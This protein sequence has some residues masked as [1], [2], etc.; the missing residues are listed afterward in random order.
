MAT[1]LVKHLRL[2]LLPGLPTLSTYC[3]SS[4]R[5]SARE[6]CLAAQSWKRQ[7]V[8]EHVKDGNWGSLTFDVIKEN[9]KK[10]NKS[11]SLLISVALFSCSIR[12]VIESRI[13]AYMCVQA[14]RL[15]T[16]A[17]SLWHRISIGSYK[18]VQLC[19]F[20]QAHFMLL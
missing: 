15:N 10:S 5:L 20:P 13:V 18:T 17:V 12:T 8:S 4:L 3:S 19:C 11:R 9:V 16:M 14:L 2:V 7:E 6:S 1:S